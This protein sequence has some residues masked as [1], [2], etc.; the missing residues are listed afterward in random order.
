MAKVELSKVRKVYPNGFKAIHGVD[1]EIADGSIRQSF[2]TETILKQV[3][4]LPEPFLH[5]SY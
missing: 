5:R 3:P 2:T 1:I 4:S